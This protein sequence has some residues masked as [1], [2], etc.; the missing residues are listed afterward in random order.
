VNAPCE[1]WQTRFQSVFNFLQKMDFED[2]LKTLK[3]SLRQDEAFFIIYTKII[4]T[5][6][7][8]WK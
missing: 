5:K 2:F 4:Y 6:I 8:K 1:K 7:K 3:K